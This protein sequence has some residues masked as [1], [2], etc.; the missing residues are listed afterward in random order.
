MGTILEVFGLSSPGALQLLKKDSDYL[1]GSCFSVRSCGILVWGESGKAVQGG[2]ES[3]DLKSQ[4][5]PTLA[6]V[7]PAG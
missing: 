6:L 7:L 2:G 5:F 4:G 1:G 3:P